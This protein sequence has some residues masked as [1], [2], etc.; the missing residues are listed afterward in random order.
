MWPPVPS[1]RTSSGRRRWSAGPSA[2]RPGRRRRPGRS[3][4][5][6]RARRRRGRPGSIR[7]SAPPG[8]TSSAGWKSSRTRPGSWP[9]SCDLGE[10]ERGADAARWCARRGRR[11]GRRPARCCAHGSSVMSCTGSASMSA[12]SATTAAARRRARRR[13]PVRGSRVTRQPA[14]STR[15][16]DAARW[17]GSRPT[18]ARGAR[19]GRGAGRPARRRDWR[20]HV[21]H[22]GGSSCTRGRGRGHRSKATGDPRPAVAPGQ[23]SGRRPGTPAQASYAARIRSAATVAGSSPASTAARTSSRIAAHAASGAAAGR[24]RRGPAPR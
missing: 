4:A 19:A 21:G 1:R 8:M 2:G 9:R 7:C 5:R 15:V 24:A 11:R 3:A 14:C 6:R 22:D 18:T 13:S 16:R 23:H 12:R 10:R 17:C 20:R